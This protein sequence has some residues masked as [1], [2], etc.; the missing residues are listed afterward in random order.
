MGYLDRRK[1]YHLFTRIAVRTSG[2]W[3]RTLGGVSW[4]QHRH[5]NV[6]LKFKARTRRAAVV[7]SATYMNTK[8][9]FEYHRRHRSSVTEET[10]AFCAVGS[11]NPKRSIHLIFPRLRN[12]SIVNDSVVN[13]DIWNATCVIEDSNNWVKYFVNIDICSHVVVSQEYLTKAGTRPLTIYFFFMEL[14]RACVSLH[15]VTM[16]F[17]FMCEIGQISDTSLQSAE[18][19]VYRETSQLSCIVQT[20]RISTKW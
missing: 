13:P 3:V 9:F 17:V 12:L 19:K 14:V 18:Y 1:R 2:H 11:R 7:Q 4:S 16:S 15:P 20:S 6:L 10:H 8:I 5:L